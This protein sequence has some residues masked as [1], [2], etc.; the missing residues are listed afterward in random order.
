MNP[1][2]LA[3]GLLLAIALCLGGASVGKRLERTEWQK[4][5]IATAAAAQAELLA[6]QERYVRIQKFNEATARKASSDHE[7]AISDLTR[8]YDAARAAI[9][10]AGGLRVSRAICAGPNDGA[11]AAAGAGGPDGAAAGTV[12]LPA[13]VEAKLLQLT[14]EADALAERLRALQAWVRGAGL[15]GPAG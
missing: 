4:K 7:K 12:A 10:A 9:R 11:A 8:Q 15:Y 6:A 13:D 14:Q 5:E 1:Y 2:A 3:G